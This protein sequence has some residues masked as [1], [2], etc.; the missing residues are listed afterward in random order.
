[1]F[2]FTIIDYTTNPL[3]DS[4]VIPEPLGFAELELVIRRD[5]KLNGIFMY[6]ESFNNL[7]FYGD[8]ATILQDAYSVNGIAAKC[9][10]IIEFQCDDSSAF[11]EIAHLKFDFSQLEKICADL[12]TLKIGMDD[13]SCSSILRN[14]WDTK[15]NLDSLKSLDSNTDNL[16]NYGA[17]GNVIGTGIGSI[18]RKND[19]TLVEGTS[20]N[21]SISWVHYDQ[22]DPTGPMTMYTIYYFHHTFNYNQ[23]IN[24]FGINNLDAV[25]QGANFASLGNIGPARVPPIPPDLTYEFNSL[26]NCSKTVLVQYDISGEYYYES[27]D[28][29]LGETYFRLMH[30]RPTGNGVYAA[31]DNIVL[32]NPPNLTGANF[33]TVPFAFSGSQFLNM[34]DGDIINIQFS[35]WNLRYTSGG[36]G[37][38]VTDPLEFKMWFDAGSYVKMTETTTCNFTLYNGYLINETLSR[39]TESVT[40]DC[41]RVY[42]DYYGRT[43]AQP[44]AS[45]SDG[46]GGLR[47]LTN[48]LLL[49]QT[50]LADGGTPEFVLSMKQS[51]DNLYPID[52]I[53]MGLESDPNRLG[54]ELL[55]V[56][57]KEYFYQPVVIA[58]LTGARQTKLKLEPQKYIQ[59][60]R[61]GYNLW[62]TESTLGLD[63][64]HS[65]REYRSTLDSI[66]NTL[67]LITLFIASDYAIEYT[68]REVGKNLVDYKYDNEIFIVQ[69][70]R[71]EETD[72]EGIDFTAEQQP[73]GTLQ[74]S[75][76]IRQ[77]GTRRNIKI[78]PLRNILRH[79]KDLLKTYHPDLNGQFIFTA[80][81]GNYVAQIQYAAGQ[82]CVLEI[83]G[84]PLFNGLVENQTISLSL[85]DDPIDGFPYEQNLKIQFDIPMSF[86]EYLAIK[87]NPYGMIKYSCNGDSFG[88]IKEIR[89]NPSEGM[90]SVTLTQANN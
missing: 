78:T 21:P 77:I 24:D 62:E 85:L 80:G 68:R 22:N 43:D 20:T 42:S 28:T 72:P 5:D 58:D 63:D 34:E 23:I 67:E 81:T 69:N 45:D 86:A 79:L 90:A 40:N 8:S 52:N 44:Y 46:C 30:L 29:A 66:N 54:Y 16:P 76:N 7:Q 84:D 56:E 37:G 82:P 25:Y 75:S 53:G 32:F 17:L 3:G 73:F 70:R 60:L 27:T 74:S 87:A 49:R 15:V 31:I 83:S 50:E 38:A 35:V 10:M 59:T 71:R 36:S 6:P 65:Q 33:D 2:R 4:T 11:V 88:W 26:L 41:L 14:R 57:P 48:G 55:R 1:M 47:S 19:W 18:E 9:E 13:I 51:F 61:F 64:V 12:C 39:I 89:Y